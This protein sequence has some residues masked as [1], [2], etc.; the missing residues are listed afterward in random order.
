MYVHIHKQEELIRLF[1]CINLHRATHSLL[2]FDVALLVF[3]GDTNCLLLIE[4]CAAAQMVESTKVETNNMVSY[5][6]VKK[7]VKEML[8]LLIPLKGS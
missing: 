8:R 6:V 3:D 7:C 1:P 5:V 4:W 2:S